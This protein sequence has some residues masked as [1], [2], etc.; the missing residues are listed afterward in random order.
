MKRGIFVLIC[1]CGLMTIA[2]GAHAQ[3]EPN[4]FGFGISGF[5]D[6]LLRFRYWLQGNVA[7]DAGL[8]LDSRGDAVFIITGGLLKTMGGAEKVYPY[9]GGRVKITAQEAPAEDVFSLAG[10][11]GAEFFAVKRFSLSG[12]S[13]LEIN[14]D[15]SGTSI[16]TRATLTLLFYLN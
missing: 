13:Q 10:L 16:G 11:L 15:E 6:S 3:G 2:D 1:W 4:K 9:F 12:E 7:F 14:F 8:G 5:E